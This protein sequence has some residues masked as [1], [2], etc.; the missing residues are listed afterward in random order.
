MKRTKIELLELR[1]SNA[2]TKE[3]ILLNQILALKA[4]VAE[5]EKQM[6]ESDDG[7]TSAR[8]RLP[9][10]TTKQQQRD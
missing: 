2:V 4:R 10:S 8:V 1:L 9:I 5:L 3:I 6:K 7:K